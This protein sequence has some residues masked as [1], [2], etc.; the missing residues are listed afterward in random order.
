[1]TSAFD[2]SRYS[3]AHEQDYAQRFDGIRRLYGQSGVERLRHAHVVIIGIGGVGSWTVEA[4]ARSGLERLTLIDLDDVCITNVNR[5]LHAL[6]G[7]IG[8]PKVEVLAE[9][10]RLINP[11]IDVKTV[12][13]F[14]TPHNIADRLPADT[15]H[16]ID[17]IDHVG[18]KTALIAYCRRQRIGLTVTGGAGGLTDPTRLQVLDLSRTEQDPLLS[19]VRALLRREHGFPRNPKRR[20]SVACVCSG[21]QR[22]YSDGAGEVCHTR[23][24][25]GE[26]LR[27]GCAG[28]FGAATFVTGAFGFAAAGHAIERLIDRPKGTSDPSSTESTP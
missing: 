25:S 9:R 27:L 15:D 14:V 28:G 16:V 18:A 24:D 3:A 12:A 17:A 20:F 2:E 19:K 10:C 5:Q 11:F 22:R 6:D 4:L 1:M 13:A 26:P 8:R 21:E 7:Q 23:P